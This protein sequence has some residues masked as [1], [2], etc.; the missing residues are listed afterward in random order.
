MPERS[1]VGPS[2]A[3]DWGETPPAL[4]PRLLRRALGCFLP[5]WRRAL[6]V[7]ACIGTGAGLGLVPAL[8]AR[9]D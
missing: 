7:L 4:S 5:H 9:H 1:C 8:A 6:W 2:M 3:V